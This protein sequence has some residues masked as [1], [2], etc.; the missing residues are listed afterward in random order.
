MSSII[1]VI[2]GSGLYEID[3]IKDLKFHKIE[4]PFGEPSDEY[5]IGTLHGKKVAFLPRHKRGHTI[6]PHELN[7][8][9]NIY[10]FKKLGAERIISL[11]AVG[12]LKE[13]LKPGDMVIVDQFYDK[14]KKIV[15]S[16]FG[17]G[18]VAHI[19]FADPVCHNL[20]DVLYKACKDVGVTVHKGGT[21]INIEGPAFSTKAESKVYRS[22]GM[23]VIGM[24]NL[25][26][27]KLS[28]EAEICYST[29]AMVTDYDC[30]YP[31]HDSV[32]VEIVIK[33]LMQNSANAKEIVKK[34]VAG[35]SGE[36]TCSCK[37]TLATAIMTQPE[38]MPE[39]TKKKLHLLIGKYVD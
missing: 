39:E 20:A 8:R 7:F 18:I 30:W 11:S 37:D 5:A 2:G 32:T 21:Y 29:V 3:G 31:G 34:A 22:W 14:T 12:S 35:I 4:T 33:T 28:R 16:F 23:D 27:A 9:A 26:E 15:H 1:G 6:L 38:K 17:E 13:E 36:R 25:M 10:G 24:T 19:P